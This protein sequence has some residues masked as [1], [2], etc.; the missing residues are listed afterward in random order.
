VAFW[1]W[2]IRPLA[3]VVLGSPAFRALSPWVAVEWAFPEL[4]RAQVDTLVW[5]ALGHA[6]LLV[7]ETL[8][9]P[10]GVDRVEIVDLDTLLPLHV[11]GQ[12]ILVAS[13]HQ[14]NFLYTALGTARAL[15]PHGL[16]LTL[17]IELRRG[18][19]ASDFV[20][21]VLGEGGVELVPITG[22]G[23]TE[24]GRAA[25]GALRALRRGGIVAMAADQES[26][27]GVPARFFGREVI[28]PAGIATL[29]AATWA[30]VIFAWSERRGDTHIV[31]AELLPVTG[32]VEKDTQTLTAAVE[33]RVRECPEQWLWIGEWITRLAHKR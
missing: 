1:L 30:P 18:D 12:G 10:R 9:V 11:E 14:G 26:G 3:W 4:T 25:L 22:G 21:E 23:P 13:L 2:F 6:A 29:H 7:P 16:T 33:R 15:A 28:A 31:R 5:R 19:A 24:R 27:P 20:A 32:S 17:P 8:A